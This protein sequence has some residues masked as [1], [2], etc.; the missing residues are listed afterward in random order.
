[1]IRDQQTDDNWDTIGKWKNIQQNE[2]EHEH[3]LPKQYFYWG[4]SCWCHHQSLV[5]W[6]LSVAG[7]GRCGRLQEGVGTLRAA[8]EKAWT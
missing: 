5:L 6:A 3:R 7:R 4:S 8:A 2:W 1:M